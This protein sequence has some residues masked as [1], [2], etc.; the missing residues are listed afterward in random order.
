MKEWLERVKVSLDLA[1]KA[2]D[3]AGDIPRENMYM[4]APH[5][6]SQVNH[7]NNAA[8]LDEMSRVNQAQYEQDCA[9]DEKSRYRYRFHYVSSFLYCYVVAGKIDE[10]KYDRIMD[11][12]NDRL[13]LFE[14]G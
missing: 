9:H 6:Y 7:M 2:I 3:S 10:A 1:E 5:F 4:L 12:V 8:L 14:D 13:D 11:Y